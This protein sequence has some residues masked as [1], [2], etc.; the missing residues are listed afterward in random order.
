MALS[1]GAIVAIVGVLIGLPPAALALQS[2]LMSRNAQA[3]PPR[4]IFVVF[5]RHLLLHS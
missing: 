3:P 2:L 1:T 5:M 4:G